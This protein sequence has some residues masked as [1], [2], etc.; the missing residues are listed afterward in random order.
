MRPFDVLLFDLGSTLIYFQGDW[1]EI[2]MQANKE[3]V[4]YLRAAGLD[5]D[6]GVF[7]EE[8]NQ[9]LQSYYS[10]RESEFVEYTTAYI[11]S[12]L[13]NEHGYSQVPD[14]LISSAIKA[15]YS[16]SQKHWHTEEDAKPTLEKLQGQGYHLGIISN[17]ADD[18]DVQTLVDNAGI[19]SYFEMVIS[20]AAVAIRKPNPRIFNM[21]L[22]TWGIPPN[23]AAMIGDTLGADVLGAQNAGLFAIWIT[24]RADT[25][26]NRAHEDTIQPDATIGTLSELLDVLNKLGA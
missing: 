16:I 20:S 13:L 5:L 24:R 22:D 1:P 23:R 8:Y 21:A 2:F 25:P 18:T 14:E 7:L 19:R 15:M 9:R 4:S 26:A 11:L 12:T 3:L 17:A 6:E 10:E